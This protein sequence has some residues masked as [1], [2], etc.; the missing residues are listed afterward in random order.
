MQNRP[1]KKLL[2]AAMFLA[3]CLALPFL[4]GQI[5][6]IGSMLLPMHIPVFLCALV[7]GWEYGLAVGLTAPLLRSV[8]FGMPPLFPT[9]VA[10]A[11][12]LGVYGLIAGLIYHAIKKQNVASVYIAMIP[13]MLVGRAVW[14]AVQAALL[15]LTGGAF[16]FEAF[17][18][19]AF[20]NA[21][22]GI[23]LQLILVPAIMLLL[24]RTKLVRFRR[25]SPHPAEDEI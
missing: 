20:V 2:L 7:C 3:L 19:G 14:G 6:Q 8:I 4:T 21:V 12:E 10:M 9:A 24:D 25:E 13:A 11:F 16:T 1:L 23:I 22:P 15:G 5:P 18:A 17:I